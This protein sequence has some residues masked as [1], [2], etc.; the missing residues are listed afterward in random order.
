MVGER[1]AAVGL[2]TTRDVDLLGPTFR[3]LWP[4]E[5]TPSFSELLQAI[6]EADCEVSRSTRAA[7]D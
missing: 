2:L 7:T 3:R 1:I 5:E 6:D 4:V